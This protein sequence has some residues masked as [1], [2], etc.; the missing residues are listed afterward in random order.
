MTESPESRDRDSGLA[1]RLRDAIAYN[2]QASQGSLDEQA[3]EGTPQNPSHKVFT[4]AN[5]ITFCRL[6]LTGVFLWLFV[7]GDAR[8]LAVSLYAVAAATDFLDGLIARSTNTVTW[9]GKVMDPLMDRVLL[10][11]GVLGLVL[12]GE[13][14]AWVAVFVIGRDAY[15][16]IG[17]LILQKY[18]RRPVDVVFSGKFA[19]ACL[20]AGFCDMLLG[21]PQVGGL[22]LVDVPWLPALN[23]EPAAVGIFFI[24]VG[25]VAST[26]TAAVYTKEGL[27]IRREAL[28][29]EA[30]S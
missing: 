28:A 11:T 18:R 14:P 7:R 8:L 13:L 4:I 22:G 3:A 20:M 30:L 15:L 27:E 26:V 10:V 24:Y 6:I 17:S 29:E 1:E 19:T 12:T 21:V 25:V 16:A 5:L 2:F 23:A 9:L